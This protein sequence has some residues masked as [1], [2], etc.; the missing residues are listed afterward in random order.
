[1]RISVKSIFVWFYY[2]KI[3]MVPSVLLADENPI[4]TDILEI[5]TL[6]EM[7]GVISLLKY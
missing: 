3:I 5:K 6:K 4:N 2:F 1:M 7:A